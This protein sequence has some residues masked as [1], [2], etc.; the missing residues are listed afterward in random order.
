MRKFFSLLIICLI[1]VSCDRGE[2][3]QKKDQYRLTRIDPLSDSQLMNKLSRLVPGG[4]TSGRMMETGVGGI[5]LSEA[6]L[7]EDLAD[8]EMRYSLG[9]M[10]DQNAVSNVV[11]KLDENG[12]ETI[13][14]MKYIPAE[15][16]DLREAEISDS[17]SGTIQMMELDGTVRL[18]AHMEDGVSVDFEFPSNATRI[19]CD[20][21]GTSSGSGDGGG[22]DGDG[23]GGTGDGGSS[24]WGSGDYGGSSE[25]G[26][27]ETSNE[28][29]GDCFH[30]I[31]GVL[32]IDGKCLEPLKPVG[33]PQI[34]RMDCAVGPLPD[35]ECVD[36]DCPQGGDPIGILK[37]KGSIA[38]TPS[39]AD[40]WEEGI[41]YTEDFETNQ[42]LNDI[43]DLM[44]QNDIGYDL[45]T[46]FTSDEPV[47]ELCFDL[48]VLDVDVNGNAGTNE[49]GTVTITINS[50]NLDK[51]KLAVARTILHEMIHAELIGMVI[52]AGMYENLQEYAESYEGDDSFM[53]IW[54]YYS[55]YGHYIKDVQAGWQHE[56]MA[57][58]YITYMGEALQTLSG[59]LLSQAFIDHF[60][61]ELLCV[62]PQVGD[63]FTW[64]WSEFYTALA[65]GGL[66]KTQQYVDSF[67][68]FEQAK[69]AIYRRELNE[70][71]L[72]SYRCN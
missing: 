2:D 68:E 47:A 46:G 10:D 38:P 4:H 9:L 67:N 11:V 69:Y 72:I 42:C 49:D 1:V 5:D 70:I 35:G 71:E 61:G 20:G 31:D 57:D 39:E 29:Q 44:N 55:E 37:R 25:S 48:K 14:L 40:L 50:D 45:L 8:G 51:S 33:G 60:D 16:S 12:N 62:D 17:F 18:I 26:T 43:L 15:S 59:D 7:V 30:L 28:L 19:D 53:M 21:G 65:W 36:D 13:Y 24:G 41:C 66:T 64:N 27:D 6:L 23:D 58:Y 56:Y 63:C 3:I 22:G 32:I 52:Q 34:A 54:E